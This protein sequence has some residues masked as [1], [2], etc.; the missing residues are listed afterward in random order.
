MAFVFTKDDIYASVAEIVK[1]GYDGDVLAAARGIRQALDAFSKSSESSYPAIGRVSDT[2]VILRVDNVSKS[3][4]RGRRVVPVLRGVSVEVHE[5]EFVAITGASGSGKSTLM[6]LMGGI[7]RPTSGVV[8]IGDTSLDK[9]SDKKLSLFRQKTVGFVFQFFYL[10]PFLRLQK[11]LEVPAMFSRTK[12]ADRQ[13][14]VRDL[15][16]KVGLSDR[17]RHF[18]RELSGGQIQRA[19]IA[20]SLMNNPRILLADE[21]TGN[22]DSKNSAAIIDLFKKIR[23]E[24]GTAV[25]IITHDESIARQA[26]RVIRLSDGAVV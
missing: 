3:Y 11:N 14:A 10:Q 6:H 22:L 17:L 8:V 21:P 2:P 12:R 13:R 9:L 5:A 7:D 24:M 25:V 4:R 23:D 16:E 19:A 1:S 20:R 26:D 18:P 15:A